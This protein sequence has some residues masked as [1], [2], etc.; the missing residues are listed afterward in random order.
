[1]GIA[2]TAF[3]V[4]YGFAKWVTNK[5][6]DQIERAQQQIQKSN[7]AMIEFMR[8]TFQQNTEAINDMC[9]TLKEHTRTKDE[10]LELLKSRR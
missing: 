8:T 2:A 1:M 6:F 3:V 5:A 10:A 7:D 4:V 9:N